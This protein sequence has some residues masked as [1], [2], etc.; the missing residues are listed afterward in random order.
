MNILH[1]R[2]AVEVEKTR[3]INRAAE[4]LYMGQP[5]L[6][7][8]I[9][10][11]ED[12]L[13][14]I[15]FKRTSRGMTPTPQGEEFLERAKKVLQQIDEIET[16][17]TDDDDENQ[18]F[19]ISVP[20]ASYISCAFTEFAKTID[21]SKQ[22]EIYYRETNALRAIRNLLEADYKLGILRYQTIYEQYFNT[23][24]AEKDLTGEMI[25]SFSYV[26]V[27]SAKSPLA[28][29]EAIVPDD[30]APYIEI[31]HA[32]PYVPSLPVGDVRKTELTDSANKR[33][34][35]FERGSQLDLLESPDMFMWGSPI[36][37][38][39]LDRHGLVQRTCSINNRRY[40]D[41]LVYRKGYKFTGLDSLFLKKLN[42]F[43]I[44]T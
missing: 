36:P 44:L 6:S 39:L 14:V 1:F 27:M 32:D 2:Y 35:V 17:F 11:L 9:K 38:R 20:R 26:L 40:K 24:L 7:R 5:N 4:N 13:G 33:I 41:I 21:T 43:R 3:S 31:G 19:S 10:D 42:E 18:R 37:Q 28:S 23:M 29:K 22:A 25:S 16:M 15:L 30:L 34:Y 12:S 8:A